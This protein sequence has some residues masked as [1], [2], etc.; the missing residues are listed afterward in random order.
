M[1]GAVAALAAAQRPGGD[2]R[3]LLH[4]YPAFSI[5]E[6]TRAVYPSEASVPE[7]APTSAG[8]KVGRRFYTDAL[9]IDIYPEIARYKGPV[10]M[11][12]GGMDT[13]VPSPYVTR[14]LEEYADAELILYPLE[15]HGFSRAVKR[16][17]VAP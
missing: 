17:A 5:S 7:R 4:W 3:G 14:A 8:I 13:V 12:H 16:T 10:L 6:Q 11:F 9:Q 2:V 15:G 1:G